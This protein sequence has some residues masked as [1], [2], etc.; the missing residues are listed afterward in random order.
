M[1]VFC[2]PSI[3]GCWFSSHGYIKPSWIDYWI[4]CLVILQSSYPMYTSWSLILMLHRKRINLMLIPLLL[5]QM[6]LLPFLPL[7]L[8]KVVVIVARWIRRRRKERLRR[9]KTNQ[10]PSLNQSLLPM[11]RVLIC[12]PLDCVSPNSLVGFTRVI[13]F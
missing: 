2:V 6:C 10:K 3:W 1:H 4:T 7:R 9:G 8:L 11:Q 13:T 5:H 12:T